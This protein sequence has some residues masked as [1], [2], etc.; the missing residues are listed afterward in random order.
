MQSVYILVDGDREPFKA[1]ASM[2]DA[3]RWCQVNATDDLRWTNINPSTPITW[4]EHPTWSYGHIPLGEERG[5]GRLEY[6]IISMV[7]ETTAKGA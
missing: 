2:D 6:S 1:F 3:K 7:I 5:A 4:V